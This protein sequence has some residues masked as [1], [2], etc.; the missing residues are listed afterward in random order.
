MNAASLPVFLNHINKTAGTTTSVAPKRNAPTPSV[1]AWF[2]VIAIAVSTTLTSD[3][4]AYCC[5]PSLL[6]IA[7]TSDELT[8]CNGLTFIY[9]HNVHLLGSGCNT[10]QRHLSVIEQT[11]VDCSEKVR[12]RWER[13]QRIGAFSVRSS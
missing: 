12:V 5:R 11:A 1:Y 10:G 4:W 3:A 7:I 13:E 6:L 2:T 8:F 9:E